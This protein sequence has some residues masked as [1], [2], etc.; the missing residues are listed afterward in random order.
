MSGFDTLSTPTVAKLVTA[1]AG[2]TLFGIG[3]RTDDMRL[4]WYGIAVVG[5]AA[6]LRFWRP[7]PSSTER[8]E[9]DESGE[10]A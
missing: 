4:R 9:T 6:A 10:N 7:R 1:V 5:I 3:I 8:Q 2:L